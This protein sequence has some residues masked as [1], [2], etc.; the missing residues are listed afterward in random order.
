MTLGERVTE[1][2]GKDRC[3]SVVNNP[4]SCFQAWR[5]RHMIMYCVHTINPSQLVSTKFI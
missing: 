5:N 4:Y 3:K 1:D 2:R